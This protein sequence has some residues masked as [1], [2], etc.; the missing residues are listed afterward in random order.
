M[1][2]PNTGASNRD[3]AQGPEEGPNAARQALTSWIGF[4]LPVLAW[5][6][7]ATDR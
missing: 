2:G 7:F 4:A 6:Y 5:G 1:I 3:L